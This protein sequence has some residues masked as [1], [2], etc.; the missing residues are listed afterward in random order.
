MSRNNDPAHLYKQGLAELQVSELLFAEAAGQQQRGERS[1]A[2]ELRT[3]A[4]AR[5]LAGV[6][7]LDQ[8]VATMPAHLSGRELAS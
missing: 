5:Q 2:I 4:L 6:A 8:A 7:L 1:K 3:E